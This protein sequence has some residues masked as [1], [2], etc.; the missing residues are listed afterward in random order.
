MNIEPEILMGA[1]AVTIASFIILGLAFIAKIYE[2]KG[3][4]D[5]LKAY[6][7]LKEKYQKDIG[8]PLEKRIGK[9]TSINLFDSRNEEDLIGLFIEKSEVNIDEKQI[10]ITAKERGFE[11]KVI[12]EN[13]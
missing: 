8:E 13:V 1:I 3:Y 7:S 11:L 5:D 2:I 4:D 9:V 6:I 10:I 12:L